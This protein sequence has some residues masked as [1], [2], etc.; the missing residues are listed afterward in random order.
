MAIVQVGTE[1]TVPDKV[2]E[3][4]KKVQDK[5]DF[6]GSKERLVAA[7]NGFWSTKCNDKALSDMKLL[8]EILIVDVYPFIFKEFGKVT[9]QRRCTV[10]IIHKMIS[11]SDEALVFTIMRIK[12][13]QV[14]AKD[15]QN[16]GRQKKEDHKIFSMDPVPEGGTARSLEL[17]MNDDKFR[18][19]QAEITMARVEET[20]DEAGTGDNNGN[21]V[22]NDKADKYSWYEEM[23]K[24][25][26]VER[27]F[28][29]I[30]DGC[31]AAAGELVNPEIM[32]MVKSPKK[33]EN[34]IPI[35]LASSTQ[36]RLERKEKKR[37]VH[38]T[39]RNQWRNK[40]SMTYDPKMLQEMNLNSSNMV[41]L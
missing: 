27:G 13:L 19:F 32:L 1:E 34:G 7:L 31:S 15:K 41:R 20:S 40:K 18:E 23:A 35:Q 24:I 26:R 8:A 22:R 28:T 21:D 36:E 9:M 4:Q 33:D 6:L 3:N 10:E 11:P 2:K 5:V 29:D 17:H 25:R 39:D 37:K 16:K 30:A 14:L 12:M 38:A